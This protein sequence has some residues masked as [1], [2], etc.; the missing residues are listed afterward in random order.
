MRFQ[1][2][3]LAATWIAPRTQCF[4]VAALPRR[5]ESELA[6]ECFILS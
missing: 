3:A 5:L 4:P 6:I 1:K 2:L